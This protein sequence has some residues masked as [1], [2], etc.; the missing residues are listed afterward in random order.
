M[1]ATFVLKTYDLPLTQGSN[2]IGSLNDIHRSS[3]T[4]RSVDIRSI[5]GTLWD[6]YTYFNI[7][8]VSVLAP[9]IAFISGNSDLI[10]VVNLQ[11]LQFVN[12]SYNTKTKVNDIVAQVGFINYKQNVPSVTANNAN[13]SVMF[14]KGKPITDLTIYLNKITD[15]SLMKALL[16][17]NGGGALDAMNPQLNFTFRIEG[18]K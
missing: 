3:M 4:W 7:T 8:L 10:G 18:V 14:Q 13:S 12:S 5:I 15:G 16:F 9:P 1:S 2:T 6:K 11:G 17:T